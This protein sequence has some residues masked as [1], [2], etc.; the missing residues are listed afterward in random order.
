[1]YNIL[2]YLKIKAK[3]LSQLIELADWT[4]LTYINIISCLMYDVISFL[5][6]FLTIEQVLFSSSCFLLS[7]NCIDYILANHYVN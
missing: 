6:C 2:V 4:A 7:C 5:T 3:I 1:M